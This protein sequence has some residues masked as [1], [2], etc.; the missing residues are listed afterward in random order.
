MRVLNVRYG[1][2]TNS[3]STHSLVFLPPGVRTGSN[4][5]DGQTYGWDFFALTDRES[6]LA[7]LS[8]SL[9]QQLRESMSAP[10]A[11]AIARDW[12]G[13]EPEAD[14][15]V[16]HQSTLTFPMDWSGKPLDRDFFM[17]FRD[18]ALRDDMVI[19]GGND[20]TDEKPDALEAGGRD[21]GMFGLIPL[22]S[23]KTPTVARRDGSYWTL[24]NREN[25]HKTRLTFEGTEWTGMPARSTAPEL[26]DVKITDNCPFSCD[27]CLDPRTPVLKADMT[28]ASIDSLCEGDEIFGFEETPPAGTKTRRVHRATVQ[29]KWSTTKPAMRVVTD[30]GEVICSLDHRWLMSHT[31][32][33]LH[34]RDLKLGHSIMF[35]V[36]PWADGAENAAYKRG[37]LSGLSCG[38]GTSRWKP[39]DDA[40]QVWWS[41]RMSDEE[42]VRRAS[43]FVADLGI[44]IPPISTYQSPNGNTMY[45]LESRSAAALD[46]LQPIVTLDENTT[47]RD[48]MRGWLG[49]FFDAEGSFYTTIRF[50]QKTTDLFLDV[51]ERYLHALGFECTKVPGSEVRPLGGRW[52]AVKLMAL[53][54]P[55]ITRKYAGLYRGGM[56]CRKATVLKL[57]LLPEQELV[58][59]Q[60]STGTFIAAGFA[61]HNCY[62][63]STPEGKHGDVGWIRRLAYALAEMRVFEVAIGGGEPT[64]HPE[65]VDILRA[66]RSSHVVPNFTTKNLAWL[67]DA[68]K[69]AEILA[70]AGAFAYSVET[71]KDVDAL[72]KALEAAKIDP[73]PDHRGG[74][75]ATVQHVVGVADEKEFRAILNACAEHHIP[76]TLLG[77]KMVGRGPSF[78]TKPNSKWLD[79]VAAVAK[80]K[81]MRVG[82]DTALADRHWDDLLKA[83]VPPYLMTRKEGQFSCYIDAVER[84]IDVSSYSG[85]SGLAL[86][87]WLDAQSL[88]AAYRDLPR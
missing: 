71:A 25:G 33:W 7:Y 11:A 9:A 62:Q 19:C 53:I 3:S 20:N 8:Q 23:Y 73:D 86:P 36:R 70:L 88:T 63:D 13:V 29:K 49:G 22:E 83:G 17:A 47:D 4:D 61:S 51:T 69:R 39:A 74:G 67:R 21:T 75:R 76:L 37:Y 38:D 77:Y 64:L 18:F 2:A 14:G 41:I 32:R 1:L 60:T 85:G 45:R 30:K 31:R 40:R 48:Y 10:A 78:G 80:K 26:V 56:K 5:A 79:I 44:D 72:A 87:E 46:R 84:K 42:A 81:Y 34:A 55:A 15:N 24:F 6:K 28:W 12:T 54:R 27:Y 82:I 35:A 68:E 65:F 50:S 16:D 57:E 58:D 52:E 59:I 66:F 43:R